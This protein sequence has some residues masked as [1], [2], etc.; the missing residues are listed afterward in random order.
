MEF[1]LTSYIYPLKEPIVLSHH[2]GFS[3][4]NP[5]TKLE[6]K[7]VKDYLLRAYESGYDY[8][9]PV[10]SDE[11]IITIEGI[12]EDFRNTLSSN[13]LV[14]AETFAHYNREHIFD[15]LASLWMIARFED[16]GLGEELRQEHR[17]MR[18]EGSLGF[19]MLGNDHR[20]VQQPKDLAHYCC[21]LSLLSH[22]EYES[23]FGRTFLADPDPIDP[24]E[25]TAKVWQEFVLFGIASRDYPNSQDELRWM[26]WPYIREALCRVA[27]Q[28][29]TAFAQGLTEKLLYVGGLLKIVAHDTRDK[30]T[31]LMLLTSIIELLLTHN[32]NF[33]RFNVED[34]ISKQFQLKASVL[35]YLNNRIR[36]INAV[37][38]RLRTIY[39]QR[40]NIVHE[41]FQA[42][43]KY[44]QSLSKKEGEEEYF[45]DLIVDLYAYVRAILEE[46]LKDQ[47]LVEFLKDN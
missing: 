27:A 22:T 5:R 32:P 41:N 20:L 25:P 31:R 38:N 14:V 47:A 46:Y 1:L 19:F 10:H 15:F 2:L 24:R 37:K 43:E 34:S 23:Y 26:F 21:L 18:A 42:V 11:R 44:I 13:D 8:K 36:D 3:L 4:D 35:I 16:E 9:F 45:D 39:Q 12:L 33:S 30:K 29:D 6:V 40:S 7:V 28:L 17:R